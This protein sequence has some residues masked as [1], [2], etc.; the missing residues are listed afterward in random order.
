PISFKPVA[1]RLSAREIEGI[2]FI[3]DTYNANPDS[4][5]AAF[6]TLKE[7]KLRERKGVVCGDMFELGADSEKLHRELG[8]LAAEMLFDFV[9]AAGPQ[10]KFFVDE[11]VKRGLDPK[12]IHHAKDA[13]GAGKLCREI[14]ATGDRVLVKGSRGMQMERVFDC[15]ITSFT[16]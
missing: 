13:S 2:V 11:A 6:E 9:I 7:F 16:R 15:F 5:K 4:Y 1:G 14:A 8:A 10:M 3:D 12:R